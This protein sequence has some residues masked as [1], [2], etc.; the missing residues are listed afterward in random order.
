ML[1]R[2]RIT[3]LKKLSLIQGKELGQYSEIQESLSRHR[4]KN[5]L[6]SKGKS[7]NK[8]KSQKAKKKTKTTSKGTIKNSTKSIM[9]SAKLRF[10]KLENQ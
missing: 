10:K 9:K 6:K 8:S 2:I 7:K 5:S 4:N 1:N 3:F